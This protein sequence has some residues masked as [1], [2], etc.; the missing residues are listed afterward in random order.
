MSERFLEG[1]TIAVSVS[2]SPDLAYLGLD[3]RHLR[4]IMVEIARH[5]MS[6]GATLVYGGDLRQH[7]YTELLFEVAARYHKD[8]DGRPALTN[9]LPWPVHIGIAPD[10]L[11]QRMRDLGEY[12]Q[13][14]R[15][16]PDGSPLPQDAELAQMQPR[17]D[18]WTPALT[19]M[20]HRVTE[21][22]QARI[23]LGGAVDKYRGRM[24]GIAE[25]AMLAIDAKQPIYLLGGFGGCTGDICAGMKLV[26]TGQPARRWEMRDLL[27]RTT[28]DNLHNGLTLA[29]NQRLACS[30]HTDE[31]VTLILRGLRRLGNA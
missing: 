2:D 21:Q 27:A 7:G 18:E 5:L 24:P 10:D 8:T 31:L 29:E 30:V 3:E 28:V 6:A 4:D 17:D 11:A 19:A 26:E 25:E 15:L 22:T 12:A 23:V 20:R 9:V 1:W 16:A 13:L 14:V